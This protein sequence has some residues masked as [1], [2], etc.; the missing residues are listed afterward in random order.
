MPTRYSWTLISF[1]TP[2][3]IYSFAPFDGCAGL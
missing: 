2:M 1:G 3:R